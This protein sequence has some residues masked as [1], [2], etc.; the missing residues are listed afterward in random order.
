M[1]CA[2]CCV[3]A[4]HV[5]VPTT[6]DAGKY[7][8]RKCNTTKLWQKH[9]P[10]ATRNYAAAVHFNLSGPLPS[11]WHWIATKHLVMPPPPLNPEDS[12]HVEA[13]SVRPGDASEPSE[14]RLALEDKRR[15]RPRPTPQ[16]PAPLSFS[17]PTHPQKMAKPA[18]PIHP[19]NPAPSPAKSSCPS[20]GNQSYGNTSWEGDWAFRR[21]PPWDWSTRTWLR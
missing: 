7:D 15:S 5:L 20:K 19:E 10:M 21:D 13:A 9:D 12:Y 4:T 3:R 16:T 11:A 2:P 6:Y 8:R 1:G 14:S 17:P 18:P